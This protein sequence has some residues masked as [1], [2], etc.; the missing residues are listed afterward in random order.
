MTAL[1]TREDILDVATQEFSEKGLAGARIDEIAEKTHTSKRMIYY[2]FG[3]K[4]E[5]YRAVLE[6]AYS[7]IRDGEQAAHFEDMPPEQA[8]RAIIG[9]NFD[10]H[11]DHPEFVRL[12]MSENVNKGE[13]IT[14]I[15][16]MRERNRTVIEALGAILRKGVE[17]GVF[18]DGIDPIDLHMTISALSFY[19]VSNRYTFLQNFGVDFS[20]PVSRARRRVQIIDCVM[21]WVRKD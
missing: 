2:H 19:N 8:L 10:Y 7:R 1:R 6:R 11:F 4:D 16:G 12:V 17:Q 5:L 15:P 3:S 9:H 21:G 14:Q 18:R 20:T 13:H